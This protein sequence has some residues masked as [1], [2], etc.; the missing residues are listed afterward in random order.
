MTRFSQI[1]APV[2]LGAAMMVGSQ[3][4]ASDPEVSA[5]STMLTEGRRTVTATAPNDGTMTIIDTTRNETIYRG[6][7]EKGDTVRVD[8]KNN[9][10]M[11]NDHVA[12]EKDLL[13]DHRYQIYF[14]ESEFREAD[15]AAH[16]QG[17]VIQSAPA[18][19]TTIITPAPS[20]GNTTIVQPPPSNNTTVIP[21]APADRPVVQPEPRS[22][23]TVVQP[24]GTV[25]KPDGTVIQHGGS[26]TTVITPAR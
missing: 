5:D 25:V 10:V 1:A 14:D 11:L 19:G 13:N 9:R 3:G 15:T 12:L 24:D 22:D 21:P 8:A 16:R 23:G 26:G 4:C 6:K 20:G 7:V 18:A 17:T 2:V